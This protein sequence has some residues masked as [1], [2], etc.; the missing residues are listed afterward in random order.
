MVNVK[1]VRGLP[2]SGKTTYVNKNLPEYVH[3]EADEY[4]YTECGTDV[5]QY[6]FDL[7]KLYLAHRMCFQKFCDAVNNGKDVVVSNTFIKA[8]EF[9]K[10]KKFMKSCDNHC[11]VKIISLDNSY[12][13]IHNVPDDVMTRMKSQMITN[14]EVEL[15]FEQ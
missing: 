3:C 7:N 12:G 6:D 5:E 9:S 4:F 13:S 8:S 15:Y 10:Y 1:F 14:E 11:K 2:G